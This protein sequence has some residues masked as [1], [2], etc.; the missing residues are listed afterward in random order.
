MKWMFQNIDNFAQPV[1]IIFDNE[2]KYSTILG[3]VVS[4]IIYSVILVLVIKS[5]NSLLNRQNPKTSM[6][7]IYRVDSPLMNFTELNSLYISMF[8]T[9]DFLPFSDPSYLTIETY[10]F[11]VRRLENGSQTFDYIPLKQVDCKIYFDSF[12]KKGFEKDYNNNLLDQGICIDTDN[13]VLGGS[14]TGDYFSNVNY[15]MKKCVNTTN[16][17]ITCKSQ[18]EIDE[19]IKGGFFQLYYID[20]YLDL[21]NNEQTFSEYFKSYFIL[22]DPK[23]TKSVDI[24]YKLVNVSSDVGYIFESREYEQVVSF[25]YYREQ[26]DTSSTDNVVIDFYINS[27]KNYLF[28][29]RSYMKFQDFA[30][31][32]GGLM[33]IMTVAGFIITTAFT[34][35]EMYAKMFNSVFNFEFD[36]EADLKKSNLKNFKKIVENSA[37]VFIPITSKIIQSELISNIEISGNKMQLSAMLKRKIKDLEENYKKKMNLGTL[38]LIKLTFCFCREK[39]KI[40]RKLVDIAYEKILNYL[41]YLKVMKT[42]LE[43]KKIK[44]ILLSPEQDK[45]FSLYSKP[46]VCINKQNDKEKRR[47]ESLLEKD[48]S[49]FKCFFDIGSQQENSVNSRLLKYMD[50]EYKKIFEEVK[51]VQRTIR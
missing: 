29:T 26:I 32:I 39:Q 23:S 18:S 1:Q 14:F 51:E 22:L 35:Y 20:N 41:D 10:Q 44:K 17:N 37:N 25:D 33:K 21:N 31:A 36:K 47:S 19:K 9:K 50:S 12:K 13:L 7:N 45:I 16:S 40:K 8:Q 48:L 3:R 24:F 46:L 15:R 28:Y 11:V 43:Y 5:W 6:T 34:Q 38:N 42:L 2:K 27:S 4:I 49:L 30:A